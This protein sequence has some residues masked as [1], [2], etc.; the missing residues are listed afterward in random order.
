MINWVQIVGGAV[1]A[2][3]LS[4]LLHTVD[5]NRIDKNWQEKLDTQKAETEAACLKDKKLTEENSR[6][7]QSKLSDL[8]GKLAAVKRVQPARCV[9]PVAGK[10]GGGDATAPANV[11]A[12]LDGVG[13]DSLFSFAGECEQYRI[14]V[15]TLQ[16]FINKVW[17]SKG[18]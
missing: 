10:A 5:V 2:F 3:A 1:A 13:T 4:W 6:E 17:T 11:N 14:Q 18:Q 8:A 7:Y 15:I 12:G 9:V 16:D